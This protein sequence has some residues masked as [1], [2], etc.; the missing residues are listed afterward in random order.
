[1]T[2][3]FEPKQGDERKDEKLYTEIYNNFC[4]SLI[5]SEAEAVPLH[6]MEAHGDK[7]HNSY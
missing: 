1:V 3:I 2:S 7:R 4:V 6:A 5:I